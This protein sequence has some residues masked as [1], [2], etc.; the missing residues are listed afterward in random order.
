MFGVMDLSIRCMS[1]YSGAGLAIMY[2]VALQ[3]LTLN[4][5]KISRQLM[6]GVKNYDGC[7]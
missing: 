5:F 6:G 4:A 7:K 1:A 3:G 2:L